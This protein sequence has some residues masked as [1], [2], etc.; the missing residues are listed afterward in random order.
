MNPLLYI[1]ID[2]KKIYT[3]FLH[4][5]AVVVGGGATKLSPYHYVR[6]VCQFEA[7]WCNARDTSNRV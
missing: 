3:V 5:I 2:E 4:A 7:L 6:I 1:E